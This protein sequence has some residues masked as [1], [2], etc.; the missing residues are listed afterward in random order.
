MTKQSRVQVAVQ[1]A[2]AG[3][4]AAAAPAAPEQPKLQLGR[5]TPEG[6]LL[7]VGIQAV[8]EHSSQRLIRY[9]SSVQI[10]L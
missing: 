7:Q 1:A 8:P 6:A 2:Q 9:T 5:P 10:R 3:A 4:E